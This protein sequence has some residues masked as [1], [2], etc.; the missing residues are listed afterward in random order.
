MKT[1]FR[2]LLFQIPGILMAGTVL[3]VFY[4]K[5]WLELTTGLLILGLWIIKDI[6]FFPFFKHS[7]SVENLTGIEQL[8]GEIG[9]TIQRL[10]PEGYIR[11]RGE[12]WK[13]RST[14]EKVI[15]QECKVIITGGEGL[16]LFVEEAD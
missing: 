15:D 11:L 13:A 3:L 12:L 2:Y 16:L 10:D 9:V 14:T 5:E 1:F 4:I 6:I 8:F 7:Y